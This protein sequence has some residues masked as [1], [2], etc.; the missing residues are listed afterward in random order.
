M[1]A[2]PVVVTGVTI[3]PGAAVGTVV[4]DEPP[5]P[6]EPDPPDLSADE[7]EREVTRFRQALLHVQATIEEHVREEHAPAESDQE[8]ILAAHLLMLDD[9]HFTNAIAERIRAERI[10]AEHA[11][12]TSF[13]DVASRL[14]F[15]GDPYLRARAEEI[16]DLSQSLRRS[17]RRDA[18]NS[19]RPT[20]RGRPVFV[21]SC[22]GATGVLRAR[23]A[24]AVAFV[25]SSTAFTSHGAILLR[26]SG[27]PALG[28][29]DL[30]SAPLPT[31]T[32]VLVDATGGRLVIRPGASERRVLAQRA[33]DVSRAS[34][35]P[36]STPLRIALGDGSNLTLYGNIDHPSQVGYCLRERLSGVGLF[37]TEFLV[38]EAGRVPA[39]DE[40][41]ARYH[42]VLAAL[43]TLPVAIRTFDLGG[44]KTVSALHRCTGPNPALG[45]R[46]LRRHVLRHPE[47]LKTQLR[48]ILRAAAGRSI[49]VLLPMVTSSEDA[50]TA[51]ELLTAVRDELR[52]SGV[53]CSTEV[54]LAAMIE[55]P[56]AALNLPRILPFV[57]FISIGTN[58]LIQYLTASDRDNEEVLHYQD[59]EVSGVKV[60][61]D[62]V[63]TTAR[64]AGRTADVTV[65]GELASTTV[66]ARWMVA[67]GIRSLSISPS[68]APDVREALSAPT[69][70]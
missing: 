7:I 15:S 51:R 18:V 31:G 20:P 26:A 53:P 23:R 21:S 37:R 3:S 58:D 41:L 16:R 67:A 27:I 64:A 43:E 61:V 8:D 62:I 4:R 29:V 32:P 22:L 60:L 65:C 39:E 50:A 57:D 59:A 25:T 52:S 40:Q 63:M 24:N 2:E 13:A 47:E 36:P 68:A 30:E 35:G 12:E 42:S 34:V 70:E 14:V 11:V 54:Q 46:G 17:L 33:L 6:L 9:H 44:D 28:A 55:V 19:D 56:S 66:G 5:P 1:G 49:A 45:V 38:L 48:A 69:G 10:P